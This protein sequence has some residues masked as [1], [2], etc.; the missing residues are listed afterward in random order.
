MRVGIIGA[1]PAGLTCA[2]QLTKAGIETDLYEAS[3]SVGGLAKTIE[4]WNQ[5]VDLGPH[6]FF[7]RDARV[8]KLWLEI[9]GTDYLMVDRLTRILYNDRLF[10]YPIQPL[11]VITKLGVAETFRCL[12]SYIR[13]NVTPGEPK[14]AFNLRFHQINALFL[15]IDTYSASWYLGA[16]QER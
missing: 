3:A 15:N 1:G 6:R 2:Y 12:L 7:S 13:E 9:V 5:R 11:D 16:V 14:A 4:L 8:N 10:R